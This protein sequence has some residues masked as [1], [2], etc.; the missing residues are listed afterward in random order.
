MRP[1]AGLVVNHIEKGREKNILARTQEEMD[2]RKKG[3]AGRKVWEK[4]EI[5]KPSPENR[6]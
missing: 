4:N 2:L 1:E 6:K 3:A 5:K